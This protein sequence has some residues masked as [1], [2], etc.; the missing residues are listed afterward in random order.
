MR[1]T[2]LTNRHPFF[3][4]HHSLHLSLSL[5][6]LLSLLSALFPSSLSQCPVKCTMERSQDM[7]FS[8]Q[9]HPFFAKYRAGVSAQGRV[10][11]LDIEV[12]HA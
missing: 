2:I 7:A 9:R 10:Q 1:K 4:V 6:S 11:A 5:L 3:T 12:Y 8:G